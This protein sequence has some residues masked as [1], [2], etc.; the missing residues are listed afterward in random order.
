MQAQAPVY[1]RIVLIRTDRVGDLVLSTPAIASFRLSWPRARIEALVSGYTE[2]VLRHNPDIDALH[3]LAD[4]TSTQQ[5]QRLARSLGAGA[6]L[7]V[8]LA[9]RAADHELCGWTRAPKRIG[10]VYR[11][12]YLSRLGARLRL[13]D[14]CI[15]EADPQ[16]ADRHP[17]RAVAHE[18]EQVLALVELA[19]GKATAR[20]LKLS[21]G[22]DDIMFAQRHVPQ[23]AVGLNLSPRWFAANFGLAAVKRLIARL[24]AGQRPLVIFYGSDVTST[25]ALVRNAVAADAVLWFGGLPLLHW[26]AALARCSVA[27]T[28][29]SGATH[30]AAAMGVPVAVVFERRFYNL[31]SQEWCPW[32]VPYVLLR[33]PRPGGSH[34]ELIAEIQRAVSFLGRQSAVAP[35]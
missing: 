7:A 14:F 31:S 12:R 20:D 24:A 30:V 28:V 13:T 5:R 11:R 4:A 35:G 1:R 15:S 23:G 3:T 22:T 32:R 18:V 16:L 26:C 29:D 33:K 19:G 6:D 2:P 17:G 27:V 21:P 10:Y 9:P 25:V 34:D 8:A